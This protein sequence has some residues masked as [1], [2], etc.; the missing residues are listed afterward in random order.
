MTKYNITQPTQ[1]DMDYFIT[2]MLRKN[3]KEKKSAGIR[4]KHKEI[5]K[6]ISAFID[7]RF[8]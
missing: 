8:L 2:K 7:R 6:E 5:E 4:K 3:K 1:K